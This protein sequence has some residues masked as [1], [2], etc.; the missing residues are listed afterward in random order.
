[1]P[2]PMSA[3]FSWRATRIHSLLARN[4]AAAGVMSNTSSHFCCPLP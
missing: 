1:L 2:M 3:P 4:L